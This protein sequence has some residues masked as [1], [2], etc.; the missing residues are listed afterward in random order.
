[1][2]KDHDA[3]C[4]FRYSHSQTMRVISIQLLRIS[5]VHEH[6]ARPRPGVGGSHHL[7]DNEMDAGIETEAKQHPQ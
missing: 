3:G 5:G 4:D 7:D 2:T 6:R 1:M